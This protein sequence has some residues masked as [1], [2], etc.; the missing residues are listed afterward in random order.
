MTISEYFPNGM[1]R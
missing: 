1:K